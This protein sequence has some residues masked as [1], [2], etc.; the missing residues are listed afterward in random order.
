M[1][2]RNMCTVVI[3]FD[4]RARFSA[5]GAFFHGIVCTVVSEFD[6]R[7]PKSS[8]S[9]KQTKKRLSLRGPFCLVM[10]FDLDFHAVVVRTEALEC[11]TVE[12][13]LMVRVS[14]ADEQFC[15]LLH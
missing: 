2:F 11:C 3:L 13:L 9:R 4:H 1:F 6:H 7:A 5:T 10:V 14:D 15:A 12:S 8:Y